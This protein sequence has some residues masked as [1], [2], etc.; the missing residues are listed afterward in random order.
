MACGFGAFELT[1]GCPGFCD[2]S[3]QSHFLPTPAKMATYE[4]AFQ[5]DPRLIGR[6]RY[7]VALNPKAALDLFGIA[8]AFLTILAA[9][10]NIQQ[11]R[12]PK[13]NSVCT[14]CGYDVAGLP[15][16]ACLECGTAGR[17]TADNPVDAR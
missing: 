9:W 14:S 16:S 13:G 12:R 1:G 11:W 15:A 4:A 17:P 5:R 8:L 10:L 7:L 6:P 3:T 2:R